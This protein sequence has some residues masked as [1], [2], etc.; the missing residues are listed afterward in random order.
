MLEFDV[1]LSKDLVP[2]VY[3]DFHVCIALKRKK[4]MDHSEMLEIP[5]KDLTLEQLH[6]LKVRSVNPSVRI[7]ASQAL[8][9]VDAFFRFTT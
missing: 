9:L 3:H 1:Q 5:M 8:I 6:E 2:V 4:G 7:S